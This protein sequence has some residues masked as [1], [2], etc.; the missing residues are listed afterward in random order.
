MN[1][2]I[3]CFF[4]FGNVFPLSFLLLC[5]NYLNLRTISP[6]CIDISELVWFYLSYWSL[7]EFHFLWKMLHLFLIFILL[8]VCSVFI[9]SLQY[10]MI[11]QFYLT[12]IKSDKWSQGGQ[13]SAKRCHLRA[14]ISIRNPSKMNLGRLAGG[15][16]HLPAPSTLIFSTR[17]CIQRLKKYRLILRV[18]NC[19]S[20]LRG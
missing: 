6:V 5:C 12:P 2:S 18:G 7:I 20:F 16:I 9:I 4:S 3:S 8:H 11:C 10:I 1:R 17:W 19:H 15:Q 14:S 13:S